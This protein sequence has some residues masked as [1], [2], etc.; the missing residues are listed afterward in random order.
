METLINAPSNWIAEPATQ[1]QKNGSNIYNKLIVFADNQAKNMTTLFSISLIAQCVLFLPLPVLLMF[2]YHVPV[3]VLAIVIT[4][5]FANIIA[6]IGSQGVRSVVSIS[7]LIIIDLI[8][9]VIF[10]V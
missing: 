5:F 8:M 2:Y 3:I 7:A 6:C 1:K 4:S 9:L 10:L